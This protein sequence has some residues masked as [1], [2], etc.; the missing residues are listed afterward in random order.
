MNL[1]ISR[2]LE[3]IW[4]SQV[5]TGP[6]VFLTQAKYRGSFDFAQDRLLH[7]AADDETIRCFDRDD[8]SEG[9]DDV[10][11]GETTFSEERPRNMI[12]RNM[13]MAMPPRGY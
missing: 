12:R 7:C 11:W 5:E 3:N 9:Q 1:R 6:P 8:V 2:D 10:F 4:G 13:D